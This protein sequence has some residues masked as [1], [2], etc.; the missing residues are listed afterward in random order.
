M[1]RKLSQ[2]GRP[3]LQRHGVAGWLETSVGKCFCGAEK[4][5]AQI[6]STT[7][8]GSASRLEVC[9]PNCNRCLGSKAGQHAKSDHRQKHT[10][11]EAREELCTLIAAVTGK[12]PDLEPGIEAY[13]Y[14][15]DHT[16]RNYPHTQSDYYWNL[17]SYWPEDGTI[18]LHKTGTVL[19]RFPDPKKREWD[20]K[21]F[22]ENDDVEA[23]QHA[24][25][26][27][28]AYKD[29]LM[30]HNHRGISMTDARGRMTWLLGEWL[31]ERDRRFYTNSEQGPPPPLQGFRMEKLVFEGTWS[32]P[33]ETANEGATA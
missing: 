14:Y 27:S 5:Y 28:E 10:H 1:G 8:D 12:R 32:P 24:V 22:T 15:G 31:M 13:M 16:L 7:Y 20:V 30:D 18:R 25:E 4:W 2:E 33:Q 21:V 26:V 11:E 17:V 6:F 19:V 3:R 9:Y 29:Y 23:L